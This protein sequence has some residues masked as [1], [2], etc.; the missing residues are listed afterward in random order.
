MTLEKDKEDQSKYYLSYPK[1]SV[2]DMKWENHD[3]SSTEWR[4]GENIVLWSMECLSP[5]VKF[6]IFI[7]VSHLFVSRPTLEFTTFERQVYST[8]QMYYHWEQTAAK[9]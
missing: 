9:K 5:T 4:L 2:L 6:D 8:T 7:T 3:T 1:P